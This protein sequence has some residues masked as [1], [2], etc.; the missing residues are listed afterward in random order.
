MSK[1]S[2]IWSCSLQV[3]IL[4]LA[5]LKLFWTK[6]RIKII[7]TKIQSAATF[8]WNISLT[9]K[10]KVPHNFFHQRLILIKNEQI[11]SNLTPHPHTRAHTRARV[12]PS[13]DRSTLRNSASL[14]VALPGNS[15]WARAA[16]PACPA[17]PAPPISCCASIC[18]CAADIQ[19]A[20]RGKLPPV[21]I[22]NSELTTCCR[23]QPVYSI[24][25]VT[26]QSLKKK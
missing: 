2:Q 1:R 4:S 26:I 24:F 6:K 17:H 19:G 22:T 3:S 11:I 20:G 18:M 8:K 16:F 10:L 14:S 9:H 23:N 13:P 25:K 15:C 5:F 21:A 7:C 12:S